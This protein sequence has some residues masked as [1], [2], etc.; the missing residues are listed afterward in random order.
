LK[1][2]GD[3]KIIVRQIRNTIHCNSSH[4]KNYQQEVHRLIEHFEA[5]NITAIPRVNNILVDSLATATSRV[6]PLEDYE[7]SQFTVEYLYKPLVPSNISNWKV[8]EGDEQIIKFLTN[9][10]NFKDLAIDDEVFQEQSMETNLHTGQPMEKSKSHTIPKGI[11]N[12]EN[13]FYLKEQFKGPKNAKIGSS[14]PMNETINIE[15]LKNP[16]NVNLGRTMMM[17]APSTT[18]RL[19]GPCQHRIFPFPLARRALEW[20]FYFPFGKLAPTVNFRNSP[21]CFGKSDFALS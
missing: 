2:F 8:F 19:E 21:F 16:K 12:L 20:L 7:A 14:Y 6:S 17:L 9:Q 18:H 3:S 1:V 11:A 13:V 15:T 10:D 5:F 4:L